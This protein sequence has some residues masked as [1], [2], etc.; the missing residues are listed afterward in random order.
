M[1]QRLSMRKQFP[2]GVKL[3]GELD[4][5][6]KGSGIDPRHIEL[7]KIRASQING[8]A[9]CMNSHTKD[10]LQLGEDPHRLYVLSG[11]R[12]A[13]DWFSEEEQTILQLTEEITLISRQGL[14]EAVYE[15]GLAL[16]GEARLAFLI[17]AIVSINAWNRVGVALSMHPIK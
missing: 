6:I 1:K 4:G 10:A 11:W 13:R 12:E 3:M 2:E 5:L 7:I 17:M 14:S 9:Y 16:F 8:C 15:K